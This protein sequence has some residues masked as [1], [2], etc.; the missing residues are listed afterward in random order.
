MVYVTLFI[1]FVTSKTFT[2][3]F[4]LEPTK[5]SSLNHGEA[6]I[7]LDLLNSIRIFKY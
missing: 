5:Y 3:N 4:K 6:T 2:A 1:V 7:E